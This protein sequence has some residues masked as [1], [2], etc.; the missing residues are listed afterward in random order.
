LRENRDQGSEDRVK[1]IR[2]VLHMVRATRVNVEEGNKFHNRAEQ[3]EANRK[4][5][6]F[7]SAQTKAAKRFTEKPFIELSEVRN[8]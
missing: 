3:I 6:A 5:N 7:K 1:Q 2:S 4:M 8:D